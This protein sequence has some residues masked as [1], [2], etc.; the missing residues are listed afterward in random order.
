MKLS[1]EQ[2]EE[3]YIFTRQH[4]VEWYDL[5]SELVDHLANAIEE[6]WKQNPND[7]FDQILNKEFKKFGVFGFMGVVEEKQKF[8]RKK[9]ALLIWNYYKEFFSFPKIILTLSFIYGLTFLLNVFESPTDVFIGMSLF[10]LALT[11]GMSYLRHRKMKI[12]ND[13]RGYK[14]LFEE[15]GISSSIKSF[16]FLLVFYFIRHFLRSSAWYNWHT[17]VFSAVLVLI[18]LFLYIDHTVIPKKVAEDLTK[19]YPEYSL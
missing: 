2:I 1:L 14:F 13:R 18:I 3:L 12:K 17:I 16:L 6:E 5:Q 15:I 8:L 19:S 11:V 4:Y 7:S 10:L 9:Y